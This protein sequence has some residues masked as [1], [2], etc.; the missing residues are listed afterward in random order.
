MN[1]LTQR[2]AAQLA[3]SIPFDF[4]GIAIP[5]YEVVDGLM[6]VVAKQVRRVSTP[7]DVRVARKFGLMADMG[8]L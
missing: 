4:K 7:R 2:R 1:I 8:A 6:R 5:P 3:R